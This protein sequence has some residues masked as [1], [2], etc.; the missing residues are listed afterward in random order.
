MENKSP[1][2]TGVGMQKIST[3][4]FS[5]ELSTSEVLKLFVSEFDNLELLKQTS[6]IS[7]IFEILSNISGKS[8]LIVDLSVNKQEKLDL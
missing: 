8:I 4:I 2:T 5:E 3:L 7:E 1:P 6:N